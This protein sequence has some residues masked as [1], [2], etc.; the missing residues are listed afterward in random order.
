[1]LEIA[2][3]Q[4]D[5]VGRIEKVVRLKPSQAESVPDLGGSG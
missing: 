4:R 5:S 3:G 2:V 1:V